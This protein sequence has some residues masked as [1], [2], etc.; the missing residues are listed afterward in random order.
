MNQLLKI[1]N[2]VR[3]YFKKEFSIMRELTG[4]YQSGY[5]LHLG[6][7][8]CGH[9]DAYSLR[10]SYVFIDHSKESI[11]L[12]IQKAI[13][14]EGLK[15]ETQI[16]K[17]YKIAL[18]DSCID[19]GFI[20]YKSVSELKPLLFTLAE[21]KRVLK[22]DALLY[23]DIS[24]TYD[25]FANSEGFSATD[26]WINIFTKLGFTIEKMA[27]EGSKEPS[28]KE[29]AQMVFLL[30]K[31]LQP[32]IMKEKN[33]LLCHEVFNQMA[34]TY[35]D[36]SKRHCEPMIRKS[37]EMICSYE[38]SYPRILDLG[39]GTGKIADW[40]KELNQKSSEIFGVDISEE[41]IHETRNKGLYTCAMQWDLNLGFS[42]PS[43]NQFDLVTA[44]GFLE[45]IYHPQHL[46]LDITRL[47]KSGGEVIFTV[48]AKPEYNYKG[49][50]QPASKGIEMNCYSES[51]VLDLI[52]K[53]G[54]QTEELTLCAAYSSPTSLDT[55][56]YWFVRAR[57][58]YR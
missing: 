55:V 58:I 32:E 53:S 10:N 31:T 43:S 25:F 30:T 29:S 57:K 40:L 21:V 19:L 16:S 23:L 9:L 26:Q 33:S 1:L 46:F 13:E 2:K 12:L 38:G 4:R 52:E 44:I 50:S 47:L 37:K 22:K 36:F 8:K 41:M 5:I 42:E 14:V 20:T 39:C 15:F 56:Y 48:E 54:L 17:P 3:L 28:E 49:R 24:N 34:P 45:F 6:S 27:G 18:H 35:D 11:E 51:E 7:E